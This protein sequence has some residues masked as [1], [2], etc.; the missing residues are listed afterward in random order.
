MSYNPSTLKPLLKNSPLCK[1]ST[2][3]EYTSEIN[4]I[5]KKYLLHMFQFSDDV[6]KGYKIYTLSMAETISIALNESIDSIDIQ[7]DEVYCYNRKELKHTLT[8]EEFKEKLNSYRTWIVNKKLKSRDE[9]TF[10][11]F[12]NIARSVVQD[13]LFYNNTLNL[14]KQGKQI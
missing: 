1:S 9:N 11:R 14:L 10:E 12:L 3:K 6:F 13:E 2:K 4:A 5:E 7:D 8:K